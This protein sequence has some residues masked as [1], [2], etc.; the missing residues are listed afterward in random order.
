MKMIAFLILI[1]SASY[2]V[3]QKV[4]LTGPFGV[5]EAVF[6]TDVG[7]GNWASI[8]VLYEDD[9]IQFFIPDI[10]TEGWVYWNVPRFIRTGLYRIDIFYWFKTREGCLLQRAGKDEQDWQKLCQV[11]RYRRNFGVIDTKQ[12]MYHRNYAQLFSSSAKFPD[13]KL[14]SEPFDAKISTLNKALQLVIARIT[15]IVQD[16]AVEACAPGGVLYV[17]DVAEQTGFC[18]K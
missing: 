3:A 7:G 9:D 2:L 6:G 1:L 5:P 16:E 18:R 8:I 17:H 11:V 10:T 12:N 13:Y 14:L 15:K 4:I